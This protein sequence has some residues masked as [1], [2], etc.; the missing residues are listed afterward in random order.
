MYH[1]P[2]QGGV[3]ALLFIVNSSYYVSVSSL[4]AIKSVLYAYI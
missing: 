1:M 3:I 4:I 2:F